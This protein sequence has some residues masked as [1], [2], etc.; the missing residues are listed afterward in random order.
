[1][2]I[3]T[4]A[5]P[6]IN[7]DEVMQFLQSASTYE[8]F[9]LKNYIGNEIASPAR[10]AHIKAQLRIGQSVE[11]FSS[12]SQTLR[13]GIVCKT[14]IKYAV[15]EANDGTGRWKVA[16]Y[17][18]NINSRPIHQNTPTKVGTLNKNNLAL[19]TTVGFTNNGVDIIGTV[20]KLNLKT[21]SLLTTDNER[22]KVYYEHLF[23][24]IDGESQAART[25]DVLP[26]PVDE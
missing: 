22:W 7:F 26:S 11:Y 15:I 1:M 12:R 24:I 21:V 19:N 13:Q 16:Y 3:N 18:I 17:S 4:P 14:N 20:T 5:A 8:L 9:R 25:F 6:A 10:L 23:P 2:T